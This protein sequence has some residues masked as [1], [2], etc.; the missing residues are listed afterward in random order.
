MTRT[1]GTLLLCLSAA[2]LA[3]AQVPDTI[4]VTDLAAPTSPA[5]VLLGVSPASVERPDNPKQF[6]ANF[7][8]KMAG[9]DGGFP[10]DLALQVAP[11]WLKSHPD[12]SM[13]EYQEPGVWGSMVQSLSL[14]VATSPIAGATKDADALGTKLGLGVTTRFFNGK[15][16]PTFDMHLQTL[17]DYADAVFR[18][19]TQIENE[20]DQE[21][22]AALEQEMEEIDATGAI[23]ARRIGELDAERVGFF[24]TLSAGQIWDFLDDNVDNGRAARRG[25]WLTGAYR[26]LACPAPNA[27]DA[28]KLPQCRASIDLIGVA[29]ALQEPASDAMLDLGARLVWSPT[30]QFNASVEWVHRNAPQ[31][32]GAN[33][34]S[35]EDSNRTAGL[36]EYRIRRDLTLY[37]SFGQDFKKPSG[38]TP[39]IATLGF[40]IGFG[41]ASEVQ[42]V[43]QRT[44]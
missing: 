3:E 24:L 43:K 12:L 10:Q 18:L 30:R 42:T 20:T 38:V 32:A 23:A 27:E 37:G 28:L 7:L 44:P 11:Y 22:V 13:R 4:Q 33:S 36:I 8:K 41:A 15:P 31:T 2:Q 29:R 1:I 9:G 25:A 21:K 26:M 35:S 6:V 40:N 39:L 34:E 16:N 5:F 19:D 17:E 14:S